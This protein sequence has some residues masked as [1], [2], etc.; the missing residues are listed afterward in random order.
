M[1]INNNIRKQEK[2]E[3]IF[4]IEQIMTRFHSEKMMDIFKEKSN[5]M[6]KYESE[7]NNMLIKQRKKQYEKNLCVIWAARD[8]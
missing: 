2:K 8:I 3:I 7:N 5:M 6:K 1:R 4:I